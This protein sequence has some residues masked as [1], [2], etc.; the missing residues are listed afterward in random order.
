LPGD[1]PAALHALAAALS[2]AVAGAPPE[3]R[4]E[5]LDILAVA[6]GLKPA[7]VIGYGGGPSA[8]LAAVEEV[9][10]RFG[11]VARRCTAWTTRG[12]LDAVPAWFATAVVAARRRTRLLAV[13]LLPDRL[14]ALNGHGAAPLAPF[15]ESAL[16]G[17]PTCCTADHA[18]W[19]AAM[20]R[21]LAKGIM[22]AAG[23]D[24][25]RARR[26]AAAGWVPVPAPGSTLAALLRRAAADHTAIVMC[27][28][29]FAFPS[30]AARRISA[31][32]AEL[33]RRYGL[34][35]DPDGTEG[36]IRPVSPA[37]TGAPF[38]APRAVTP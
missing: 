35:D 24:E 26:L 2:A 11:L 10:A 38:R 14:H 9:A 27:P 21:E 5:A 34:D 17:Y 3:A 18:E 36:D 20:H 37:R 30:S 8:L 29:C 28:D 6:A 23:A 1:D 16:L 22:T 13:S 31:A 32:F 19:R 4:R 25:Q 33:A 7:A 12:E 15:T